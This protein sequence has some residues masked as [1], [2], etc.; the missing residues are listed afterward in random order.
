MSTRSTSGC[1]SAR[2]DRPTSRSR[3]G[4]AGPSK[5]PRIPSSPRSSSASPRTCPS[6]PGSS[7]RTPS[8]PPPRSSSIGWVRRSP[9]CGPRPAGPSTRS[10]P[11]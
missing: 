2:C 5:P 10:W 9:G 7:P 1:S 3:P 11:P 8:R 4:S 6:R